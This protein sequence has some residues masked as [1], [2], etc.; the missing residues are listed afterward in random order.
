MKTEEKQ[1]ET[2]ICEDCG[3]EYEVNDYNRCAP[4]S[5]CDDCYGEYLT[6]H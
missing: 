6:G 2:R 3:R 5:M 4:Y 1:K